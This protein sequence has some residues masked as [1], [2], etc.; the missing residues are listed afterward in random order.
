MLDAVRPPIELAIA[1]AADV[2]LLGAVQT[3]VNKIRG[4]VFAVGP[5][6]GGIRDNKRDVVSAKKG[7]EFRD[8]ERRMADF[9][10]M[11]NRA[12]RVR[13]RPGAAFH[14]A[15]VL[16]GQLRSCACVVRKQREEFC[17]P[18]RVPSE[19]RRKLPQ[20]WAKLFAQTQN[21]GREKIRERRLHLAQLLHV[22]DEARALNAED[23]SRRRFR[24]P[25]LI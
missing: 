3:A 25:A 6:A 5:F 11:T 24:I 9:E 7:E 8:H 21:S 10:A 16:L 22:S 17:E 12:S 13:L 2:K 20:N 1:V 15:I 19:V 14:F 23:K 4:D 18:L